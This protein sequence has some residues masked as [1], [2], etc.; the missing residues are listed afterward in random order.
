LRA[1]VVPH[2][3]LL[4]DAARRALGLLNDCLLDE[5]LRFAVQVLRFGR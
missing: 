2:A 4:A 5:R 3:P 1:P